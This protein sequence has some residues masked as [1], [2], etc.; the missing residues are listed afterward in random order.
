[1]RFWNQ[2]ITNRVSSSF[3]LLSL[4][5]VGVVGGVAFTRAREALKQATFNQLN[6]TANLKEEEM[7]RWFE[8]QQRDV[9]LMTQVPNIQDD[10]GILLS[11]R[12]DANYTAAHEE[13]SDY[14]TKFVQLKP[15]LLEVSILDSSNRIV[16]STNRSREGRYEVLASVT[17]LDH[18][19]PGNTFDPIFY[20]SSTTGKPSVTLAAPLRDELGTRRGLILAHLNLDRIDQIVRERTGLGRSGE[21]YLVGSFSSETMFIS[22]EQSRSQTVLPEISSHGIDAAMHGISGSGLYSNYVG[23]SVIGVYRWL[24]DRDIALLVEME[25]NEA[26]APARQLAGTIML[27]GLASAGILAIGVYWLAQQLQIS[28]KQLENYSRQLEQKAQEA[29]TANHAK[30][31]FLSNM[32]HEFR[33]PLNV[34]LGFTQLMARS[35][36]L[37]PKQQNYLNTI[38]RSGEHLLNLINDVLE[39]SK[40]EAGRVVL[41]ESSFN[42][43]DLLNSLQQMFHFKAESKGLQLVFELDPDL[44]QHIRTDESKLRQVL[45]NLLSNAIKFTQTGRVILRVKQVEEPEKDVEH[46]QRSTTTSL[47]FEVEDTGPGISPEAIK[48]L[49]EPFVQSE[50]GRDSQ[51]GTGLGLSISQKFVRL[52]GGRISV[53]SRVGVGSTFGFVIPVCQVE[54]EQIQTQVPNRHVIGLEAG[55]PNYRILVVEDN[56]SNRQLLVELLTPIG[57]EVK[58]ATNGEE[59]IALSKSWLPHL[60][61]MDMRMPIVN[62]YKATQQ[63]KAAGTPAPI[64]IALTGSAFE[65]ERIVALSIG[66]DDFVRKPVREEIIFEKMAQYL[67]V[68][69]VYATELQNQTVQPYLQALTPSDLTVMPP[70]WI[71]QL[72]QAATKVN[73]KQVIA[74]IQQVPAKNANLATHLTYLVNNFRFEEIISLCCVG[75][76]KS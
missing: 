30:S 40:I 76:A 23:V 74:L 32:S 47:Q 26:F 55:Q 75:Q 68:R 29:D 37:N 65:E 17:Y 44:P 3:L 4:V 48:I 6:V 57:F 66:C 14:L 16:L 25:Q 71:E 18:V 2:N 72:H 39:M 54:P 60:I 46:S 15:S 64:V 41:S 10:L 27:V 35:T 31:Q 33:T 34:I 45:M 59:A 36:S 12:S 61:W 8:D 7:S 43:Y 58:E 11:E 1:M 42:L 13:L 63:I 52:M 70:E 20:V 62:G 73:A 38:S 22:R 49:F 21:T 56:L 67:D 9:L 19:E 51:E 69:Y 53:T 24:N 5:T 28:R 50:T